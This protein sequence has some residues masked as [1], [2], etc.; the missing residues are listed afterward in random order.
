MVIDIL[1]ETLPVFGYDMTSAN[2]V[3]KNFP[4]QTIGYRVLFTATYTPWLS[5]I[6]MAIL[7]RIVFLKEDRKMSAFVPSSKFQ[8]LM[9]PNSPLLCVRA[10][11]ITPYKITLILF[12]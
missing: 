9:K 4:T 12:T 1:P 5:S 10:F 2:Q 11:Y 6:V 3:I 7:W 8:F